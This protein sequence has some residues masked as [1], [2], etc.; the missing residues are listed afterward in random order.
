[1]PTEYIETRAY[2]GFRARFVAFLVDSLASLIPI[3]VVAGLLLPTLDL[4]AIDVND[5]AAAQVLLQATLPRLTFDVVL[6]AIIVVA[7]WVVF[8]ANPGKK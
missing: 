7:F 2:L 1:M 8:A 3:S 5:P 6:L 4:A